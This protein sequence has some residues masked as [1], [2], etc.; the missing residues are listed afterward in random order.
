MAIEAIELAERHEIF[1]NIKFGA[2]EVYN[3][4]SNND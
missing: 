1:K 3:K 4:N 2:V